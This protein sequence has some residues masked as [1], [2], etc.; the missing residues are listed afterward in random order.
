MMPEVTSF[1]LVLTIYVFSSL[2]TGLHSQVHKE[3][4][5]KLLVA[6]LSPVY[7][8][9]LPEAIYIY[10]YKFS[11]DIFVQGQRRTSLAGRGVRPTIRRDLQRKH[12]IVGLFILD[13]LRTL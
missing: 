12:R 10:M 7:I 1:M 13:Y 8:F 4:Q 6:N 3:S 9:G 2:D 5:F 11:T